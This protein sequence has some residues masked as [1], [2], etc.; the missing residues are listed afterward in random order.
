MKKVII[1]YFLVD[2]PF[3]LYFKF[4]CTISFGKQQHQFLE[5]H[6]YHVCCSWCCCTC[7]YSIFLYHI[8]HAKQVYL[9]QIKYLLVFSLSVLS[10]PTQL[11]MSRSANNIFKYTSHGLCVLSK[12]IYK[13]ITLYHCTKRERE[14]GSV[15]IGF[16][17]RFLSV[18]YCII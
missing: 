16:I 6:I 10:S 12:T 15:L 7:H 1:R 2:K 14:S 4:E 9:T 17:P 8:I 3:V 11:I 5:L 18:I 13:I